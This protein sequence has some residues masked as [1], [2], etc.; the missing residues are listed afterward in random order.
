MHKRERQ[1]EYERR[2]PPGGFDMDDVLRRA[3]LLAPKQGLTRTLLINTVYSV[4][5]SPDLYVRLRPDH[6]P[7]S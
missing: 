6:P 2:F 5:G 3:R 7:P 4:P 1:I